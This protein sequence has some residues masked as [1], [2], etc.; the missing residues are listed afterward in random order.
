[1]VEEKEGFGREKE[2][3]VSA[4]VEGKGGK[5]VSARVSAEVEEKKVVSAEEGGGRGTAG[6]G[7]SKGERG[8]GKEWGCGSG[9]RR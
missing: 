8:E 1:V 7:R 4:E 9:R 5:A 6:S 3:V 2:E